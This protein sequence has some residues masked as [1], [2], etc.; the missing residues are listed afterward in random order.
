LTAEEL[1][2][3]I[4]SRYCVGQVINMRKRDPNTDKIVKQFKVT[5]LEFYP[6]FVLTERDGFKESFTYQDF[7]S[8]T[9]LEKG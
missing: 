8:L 1:R 7:K 4:Y 3:E 5:I 2:Q 9:R 6:Y